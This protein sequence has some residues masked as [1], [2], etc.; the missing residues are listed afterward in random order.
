MSEPPPREPDDTASTAPVRERVNGYYRNGVW[1]PRD[2]DPDPRPAGWRE[3][4][5]GRL[6]VQLDDRRLWVV[7]ATV[8]TVFIV[9]SVIVGS[10]SPARA[11]EE[12]KQFLDAVKRG[13]TA[14]QDGNDITLVTAARD[15]A[16]AVCA[17]LPHDGAVDDWIGT[18]EKVGTVFGGKKGHLSVSVGE[19]VEL[20]TWK[21][22]S[23]DA[24]DRTLVDPNSDVYQALADLK[25]GD[26]VQFS[27]TFE[28]QGAT[29]IHET[30][31]FAKNGML[32][33]GFVFRFT[34]VSPR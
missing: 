9:L 1:V 22:E 16:S 25:A 15:R 20:R 17:L 23:D 31:T 7:V 2:A 13:Q 27:G 34:E 5:E 32:T 6:G 3:R 30:S 8:A 33:P 28:P 12:E 21:R 11:P 24:K 10:G 14:V 26:E 29:C 18:I 19:D 4:V